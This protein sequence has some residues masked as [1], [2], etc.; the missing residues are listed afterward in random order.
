[1]KENKMEKY[2]W[3]RQ[4]NISR[5]EDVPTEINRYN[6]RDTEVDDEWLFWITARVKVIHQLDLDNTLVTDESIRYLSKL[7]SITELRLKGCHSISNACLGN[8]NKL[9]GLELLHLQ[10]TAVSLNSIHELKALK[11]LKMLLLS[12]DESEEII[13][14]KAAILKGIFPFCE[15]SLTGKAIEELYWQAR[16]FL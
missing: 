3:K 8:L 10:G 14:E 1:M 5:L 2:F 7:E 16:K 15:I 9:T 13:L 12:S 4:F 11:N 6:F